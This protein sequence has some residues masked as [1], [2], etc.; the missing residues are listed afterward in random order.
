MASV[1]THKK[2]PECGGDSPRQRHR[3]CY[4]VDGGASF[5]SDLGN[6]NISGSRHTKQIEIKTN[7]KYLNK[8]KITKK[9]KSHRSHIHRLRTWDPTEKKIFRFCSGNNDPTDLC[10]TI[11]AIKIRSFLVFIP[12][13]EGKVFFLQICPAQF[14]PPWSVGFSHIL[15][16]DPFFCFFFL[17]IYSKWD[18]KEKNLQIFRCSDLHNPDPTVF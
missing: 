16:S 3:F 17:L 11:C 1:L 6:Q 4:I 9:I 8:F 18:P 13:S 2:V 14:V 5:F 7:T 10:H 12:I 15:S